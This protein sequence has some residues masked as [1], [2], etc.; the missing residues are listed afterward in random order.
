MKQYGEK[1]WGRPEKAFKGRF[2]GPAVLQPQETERKLKAFVSSICLGCG[3]YWYF[4]VT[5]SV[6]LL[7][8]IF[9]IMRSNQRLLRSMLHHQ[10]MCCDFHPQHSHPSHNLSI[11]HCPLIFLNP[12]PNSP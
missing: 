4:L 10:S 3:I 2:Q 9:P 12:R 8:T 11:L 6:G 1:I 5:G 7:P